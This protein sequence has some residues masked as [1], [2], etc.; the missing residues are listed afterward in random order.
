MR[1]KEMVNRVIEILKQRGTLDTFI[2][3]YGGGPALEVFSTTPGRG[4]N[5][6]FYVIGE[7]SHHTFLTVKGLFDS[8]VE[9]AKLEISKRPL[10]KTGYYDV[11]ELPTPDKNGQVIK[12]Y[13]YIGTEPKNE[14]S[15]WFTTG[16]CVEL[17]SL[18]KQ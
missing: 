14:H 17:N 1:R 18:V 3:H 4:M 15:R 8:I 5:F 11:I 7:G 10:T 6:E 12:V 9:S 13:T 2:C 16:Y